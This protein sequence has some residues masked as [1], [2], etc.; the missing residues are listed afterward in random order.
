MRYITRHMSLLQ[1]LRCNCYSMAPSYYVDDFICAPA[2]PWSPSASEVSIW[3]D[4]ADESTIVSPVLGAVPQLY[5]WTDKSDNALLFRKYADTSL[6]GTPH[7]SAAS[8]NGKPG[9]TFNDVTP[10]V[11]QNLATVGAPPAAFE[12]EQDYTFFVAY[13]SQRSPGRFADVA[14]YIFQSS[15]YSAPNWID[16]SDQY[17]TATPI[18]SWHD[19]GGVHTGGTAVAGNQIRTYRFKSTNNASIRLNGADILTSQTYAAT[20]FHSASISIGKGNT[21]YSCFGGIMGELI[22]YIGSLTDARVD[23]L[24]GYLAWKW[25][26]EG[27]LP[28]SH[29]Y[30]SEKPLRPWGT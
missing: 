28:A 30:K 25:G 19:K 3:L 1:C 9:W 14:D 5:S 10:I 6:D 12:V 18:Y 16:F 17:R 2:C 26:L 22:M 23:Q 20:K 21:P 15:V 27:S 11:G 24:E 13:S 7:W 4:A 29:P 8:F